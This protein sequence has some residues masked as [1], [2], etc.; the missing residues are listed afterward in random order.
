MDALSAAISANPAPA[1]LTTKA[2]GRSTDYNPN[3]DFRPTDGAPHWVVGLF[4]LPIETEQGY[5]AVLIVPIEQWPADAARNVT[6]VQMASP[7]TTQVVTYR[8]TSVQDR[9]HRGVVNGK[10]LGLSL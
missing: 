8:V 5:T 10:Q 2:A 9:R 7:V 3:T 1:V 4:R 6:T